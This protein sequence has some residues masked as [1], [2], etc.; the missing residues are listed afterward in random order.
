M[1][2]LT[3]ILVFGLVIP[4]LLFAAM[5]IV[6]RFGL[7]PVILGSLGLLM[8]YLITIVPV[9]AMSGLGFVLIGLIVRF[10][11]TIV[12]DVKLNE[13]EAASKEEI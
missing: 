10:G 11:L 4:S 9:N 8:L 3:I 6:G 1:S 7:V 5:S 13:A 2:Y 12:R